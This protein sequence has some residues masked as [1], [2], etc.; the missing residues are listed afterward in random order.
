MYPQQRYRSA[1][2]FLQS[3][4]NL[5]WAHLWWPRMQSSFMRTIKTD[6]TVQ[7]CRLIWVFIGSTYVKVHFLTLRLIFY[8]SFLIVLLNEETTPTSYLQKSDYLIQIVDINSH[9]VWQTVQIQISWLLQ[10]PTD[11]DLHCLQRQSISGFSRTSV[12]KG[13]RLSFQIM[14]LLRAVWWLRSLGVRN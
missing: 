11:L 7:M 1:C 13:K 9:T 8:F 2:E 3:D 4:E 10:K 14:I 12:N 6:Q 5:H